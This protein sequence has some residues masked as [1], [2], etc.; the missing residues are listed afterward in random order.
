MN[1]G[2]GQA[3]TRSRNLDG[4]WDLSPRQVFRLAHMGIR[5][6]VS[7][8]ISPAFPFEALATV[9]GPLDR[10][11]LS[12]LRLQSDRAVGHGDAVERPKVL[13]V[14]THARIVRPRFRRFESIATSWQTRP[15]ELH[16]S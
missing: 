7:A 6:R 3:H 4:N 2:R 14:E 12:L 9:E 13:F 15:A 16:W 8:G 5:L 10:R 11:N 1:A